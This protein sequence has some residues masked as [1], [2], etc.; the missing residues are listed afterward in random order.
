MP[1]QVYCQF[2]VALMKIEHANKTTMYGCHINCA[3]TS[4]LSV[5]SC[6][7]E[8]RACQT[9]ELFN[10][11]IHI[12]NSAFLSLGSM[13]YNESFCSGF[14]CHASDLVSSPLNI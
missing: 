4:S 2:S 10:D 13:E 8:V 12:W 14:I 7:H 9:T 5:F 11:D 3:C 6:T 1:V